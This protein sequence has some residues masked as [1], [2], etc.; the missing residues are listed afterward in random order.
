METSDG[1]EGLGVSFFGETLTP[2]LKSAID[3][4][5]ALLLGDD[6]LRIE[7]VAEKLRNAVG[8]SAG[9]GG[10]YTLA[11]SAPRHRS[12]GHQGQGAGPTLVEIARRRA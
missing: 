2:A 4:M 7:A 6:P 12:L 10:I 8:S 1:T 9:P 3:S 5:G 11:L